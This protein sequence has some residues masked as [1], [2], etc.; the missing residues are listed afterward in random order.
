MPNKSR[1]QKSNTYF[2]SKTKTKSKFTGGKNIRRSKIRKKGRVTKHVG[3]EWKWPWNWF[4]KTPPASN[5]KSSNETFENSFGKPQKLDALD[6]K[7]V[8]N[9][10]KQDP[11]K[12]KGNNFN[13]TKNY[14]YGNIEKSNGTNE[15][16]ISS[17]SNNYSNPLPSLSN[18]E[19]KRLTNEAKENYNKFSPTYEKKKQEN[20]KLQNKKQKEKEESNRIAQE[21]KTQK[22][23]EALKCLENIDMKQDKREEIKVILESS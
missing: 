9:A 5:N 20:Q 1:K 2:K 11:T 4:K 15:N 18:K 6:G 10:L 13:D 22:K 7:K 23:E 3:G 16:T 19:K 21:Q 12:F 14:G 8:Q 17:G